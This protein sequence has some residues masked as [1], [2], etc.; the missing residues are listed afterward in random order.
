MMPGSEPKPEE[1]TYFI[2]AENAAEMARLMTLAQLMTENMGGIFPP[3]IDPSMV[4]QVLDIACGPGQ[5]A[6]N[7]ARSAPHIQVTG[8]DIS[9]LM[10]SYAHS[11]TRDLPNAHFRVMDARQPL[12]FPDSVFNFVQARFIVAF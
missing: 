10:I 6:L 2:D 4:Y 12:D 1:N 5:W 3:D 9:Q 11:L 7:M 8:I